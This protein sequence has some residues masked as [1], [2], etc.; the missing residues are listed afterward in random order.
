MKSKTFS[1]N[2]KQLNNTYC[3]NRK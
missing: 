3:N 1:L 2:N